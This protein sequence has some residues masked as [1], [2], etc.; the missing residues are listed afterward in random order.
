MATSFPKTAPGPES[1]RRSS[2]FSG[3]LVTGA[4]G[5]VGSHLVDRYLHEGCAV[6][7][8]D[9]LSTGTTQNLA[10]ARDSARFTFI[11]ADV[12]SNWNGLI[13]E[14]ERRD[15]VPDA[16][17]HFASPASPVDYFSIPI[18]TMAANSS[19]T[20]E[21]LK[22]AKRWGCRFL[23]ASTSESYGDPLI[24]PQ[25]EDYWG[26]VNPVGPRSC[27][28][29]S[30]R[31]GEALTMAYLRAEGVDARIIRIFN[32]YGPRMRPKDGRVVS[33]FIVQALNG[34][35]LTIYGDGLQT[36]SFCYVDDLVE[37]IVR[38]AASDATR[39]L[40]VNLGNPDEYTIVELARLVS[41]MLEVALL[42]ENH[43]SREDDPSRRRP[44]I[45]LARRLLDWEPRVTCAEGL[46][47]TVEYFRSI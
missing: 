28:D 19:G 46:H 26:N 2:T 17:L 5:F 31:F 4:A 43:P 10:G 37:G 36:R 6:V 15:I 41:E 7:G 44:D 3:V 40:V 30:K 47:R 27:Y 39:G 38:C 33:S 20:N 32:T 11:K 25:R 9:N 8:V 29:E 16:I 21:C 35:A 1:V 42:V 12:A 13:D 18:A 34:E 14:I 23:Y 45:S 22:A 24:H